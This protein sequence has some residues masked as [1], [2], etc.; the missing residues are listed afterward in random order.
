MTSTFPSFNIYTGPIFSRTIQWD[1][2]P[3][4]ATGI[5]ECYD[6]DDEHLKSSLILNVLDGKIINFRL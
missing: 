4:D 2:V 1:A 3:L 5:Y 6:A